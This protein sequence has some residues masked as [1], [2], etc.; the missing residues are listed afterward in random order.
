MTLLDCP[1]CGGPLGMLIAQ[2]GSDDTAE[3]MDVY[4]DGCGFEAVDPD[5]GDAVVEP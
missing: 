2:D 3:V 1:R 4:C 5:L